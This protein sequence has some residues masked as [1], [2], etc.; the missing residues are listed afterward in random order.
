MNNEIEQCQ[1]HATYGKISNK[2]TAFE[3]IGA[4][5]S[6]DSISRM[7]S[8]PSV[9]FAIRADS[10]TYLKVGSISASYGQ[11]DDYRSYNAESNEDEAPP[12]FG[13]PKYVIIIGLRFAN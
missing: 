8:T 12:Q 4:L 1:V 2:Y 7:T 3:T 11:D 5:R 10:S 13:L 6:Q 9:V